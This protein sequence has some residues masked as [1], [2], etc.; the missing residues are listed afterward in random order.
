M[1]SC[2]MSSEI[3]QDVAYDNYDDI[4]H[5][6]F[7]FSQIFISLFWGLFN[8]ETDLRVRY[9][10]S[11]PASLLPPPNRKKHNLW[12]FHN[13]LFFPHLCKGGSIILWLDTKN[14]GGACSHF[15]TLVK[16]SCLAAAASD[17]NGDAVSLLLLLLLLL[18]R[19]AK[20]T[21]SLQYWPFRQYTLGVHRCW[22]VRYVKMQFISN[23][24]QYL[25]ES[26]GGK[27]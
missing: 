22:T 18:P 27:W 17:R 3:T 7:I 15:P 16:V 11:L 14:F 19:P 1:S 20:K 6:N 23:R 21:G 2:D 9:F 12:I 24:T 5:A 10:T 13:I 25:T 26:T 4:Q 8:D